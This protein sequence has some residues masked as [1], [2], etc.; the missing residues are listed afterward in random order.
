MNATASYLSKPK[1]NSARRNRPSCLFA[2]LASFFLLTAGV[3]R[4]D[5]AG[6]TVTTFSLYKSTDHGASWV[7]AGR[8]LPSDARINALTMVRNAVVAGTDQGVFISH[9]AG[10]NWQSAQK[11]IGTESRVLCLTAHAGRIFAGTHRHGVLRSDDEGNTWSAVNTGLSDRHIRSML[12]VETRLYA[13]T[14]SMGVFASDNAGALW[15]S[16]RAG[17]PDSSQVFDLAAVDGTVFAG[18]YSQ[19]LY[20]WEANRGVWVKTGNVVPLELAVAGKTL[21]AGHNP[22]GIFVSED[23]GTTWQDGNLGLPIDAPIWTLAAEA[24]R[25]WAGT[26]G[27]VG[28]DSDVIGLFASQDRGKSWARSDAGLPPASATVSFVIAKQFILAGITTPKHEAAPTGR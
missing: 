8:G 24:E 26:T 23:Q 28:L 19:G 13:G 9:D 5:A 1:M 11:G 22:G 21:V 12:A 10:D 4:T 2:F 17:L 27:R 16:Q 14:D 25:V 7:M 20:R 3:T 18:L 15:T 6:V